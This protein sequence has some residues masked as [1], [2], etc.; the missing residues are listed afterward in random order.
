MNF[1]H[2]IEIN[3]GELSLVEPLSRAQLWRGL[4]IR[5]ERPKLFVLGLDESEVEQIDAQHLRRELRFGTFHVRDEVRLI[6]QEAV[7][8]NVAATG[9]SPA[10]I[11]VMRI[12]EPEAGHLFLRFTYTSQVDPTSDTPTLDDFVAGHLKQAYTEADID[13]VKVIRDLASQGLLDET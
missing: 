3:S 13:T 5:A 10:S 8:Y 6:P 4:V 12:E 1:E 2:L 9:T 11:L 7:V